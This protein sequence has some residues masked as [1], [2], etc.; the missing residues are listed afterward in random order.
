M[1]G[2]TATNNL[3]ILHNFRCVTLYKG[4]YM[5]EPILYPNECDPKTKMIKKI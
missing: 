5:N 4:G 1:F 3:I 2:S